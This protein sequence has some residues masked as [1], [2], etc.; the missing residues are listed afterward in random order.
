MYS[1]SLEQMAGKKTEW[2]SLWTS[3]NLV[4]KPWSEI[5][6]GPVPA[7][8]TFQQL[9]QVIRIFTK[10]LFGTICSGLIWMDGWK[11]SCSS[12]RCSINKEAEWLEVEKNILYTFVRNEP[13]RNLKLFI[14]RWVACLC[15]ISSDGC[16]IIGLTG[17]FIDW[18]RRVYMCCGHASQ[19][20]SPLLTT[21]VM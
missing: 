10:H 5:T 17:W 3:W 13:L 9:Q 4:T 2:K 7:Q 12:D 6:G 16:F 20:S 11:A 18:V 21:V 8:H 15:F 19:L 14:V 1:G